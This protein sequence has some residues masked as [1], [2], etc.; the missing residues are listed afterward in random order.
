[1]KN[2]IIHYQTENNGKIPIDI[3]PEACQKFDLLSGNIV[4][5]RDKHYF[6]QFIG[7]NNNRPWV[8]IH[9]RSGAICLY[10]CL[11]A[12]DLVDKKIINADLEVNFHK[13]TGLHFGERI[14]AIRND[15]LFHQ[16]EGSPMIFNSQGLEFDI[17][18]IIKR[19]NIHHQIILGNFSKANAYNQYSINRLELANPKQF[20]IIPPP[21]KP[22]L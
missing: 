12:Q 6:G 4:F 22:R 2:E 3:S 11:S 19:E 1:M 5:F 20:Q 18:G 13:Q 7:E 15:I 21:L 16:Y 8:H 10:D 9:G 14:K 17:C